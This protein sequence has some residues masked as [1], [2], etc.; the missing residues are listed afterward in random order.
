MSGA[1]VLLAL[2]ELGDQA[3]LLRALDIAKRLRAELHV[4]RVIADAGPVHP[5][6]PHLNLLNAGAVLERTRAAHRRTRAWL[7]Q[8][9][10]SVVRAGDVR[11]RCGSFID[12]VDGEARA[13]D[14]ELI[15]VPPCN[16]RLGS[17]V[18]ALA[19]RA[20][21]PVLVARRPAVS[22]TVFAA[23]DLHDAR[24]RVLHAA[25][26]IGTTLGAKVVTFQN[27]DPRA[28]LHEARA[29]GAD[30]VVVGTHYGPWWERLLSGSISSCVVERALQS[31]LVTPVGEAAAS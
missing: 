8:Q 9:L 22:D 26:R 28:I 21:R 14:A 29:H 6:F 15:V 16:W 4:L 13:L 2:S 3:C 11:V 24:Y 7:D 5:T 20:Q 19:R 10:P 27:V 23:T 17:T 25:S 31:V 18:T 30:L 1:H 12:Q